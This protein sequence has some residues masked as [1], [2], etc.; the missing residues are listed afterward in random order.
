VK[1]LAE[2]ISKMPLPSAFK[3]LSPAEQ[4]AQRILKWLSD[5][6]FRYSLAS[7]PLKAR[8]G[9]GQLSEFL[10]STKV[11][12]CEHYSAAFTS[13]MRAS[14]VPARIVIGYQGAA[15]A[16]DGETWVIRQLDS[17]AWTEI[18]IQESSGKNTSIGRWARIDPTDAVAPL[19]LKVGGVFNRLSPWLVAA[20]QGLSSDEARKQIANSWVGKWNGWLMTV[21][22]AHTQWEDFATSEPSEFSILKQVRRW[23]KEFASTSLPLVAIV[24]GAMAILSIA[25]FVRWRKWHRLE[26]RDLAI[27]RTFCAQIE[28]EGFA[29]KPNEGPLDFSRRAARNFPQNSSLICQIGELFADIRYSNLSASDRALRTRQLDQL[30]RQIQRSLSKDRISSST[31]S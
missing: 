15:L 31:N 11:G 6:G 19:R 17:H 7:P 9:V 4:T 3:N 27:W 24:A 22:L 13:L 18:W 25:L 26:Q 12:F 28:K 16:D 10:F 2:Q 20:L 29:R 1:K 14:G 30:V 21:N 8:D 23:R 5:N